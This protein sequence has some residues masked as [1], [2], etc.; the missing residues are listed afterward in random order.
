[1]SVDDFNKLINQVQGEDDVEGRLLVC[2]AYVRY[3]AKGGVNTF[4][5]WKIAK[6][7]RDGLGI[8]KKPK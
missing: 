1:M 4:H 5:A 3:I 8:E 7:I 6:L 2:E